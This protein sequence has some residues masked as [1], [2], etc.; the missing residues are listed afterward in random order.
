M[1]FVDN[2]MAVVGDEVVRLPAA[3]QALN[4]RDVDYARRFPT[5][6]ADDANVFG[7]MFRNAFR[8]ATH[9]KSS[10]RR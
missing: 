9:C 10:S 4:K 3:H 8:R 7:A 6:A 2:E 5:P 1:A